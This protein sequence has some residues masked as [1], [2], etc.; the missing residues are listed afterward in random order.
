MKTP[1][2]RAAHALREAR[3]ALADAL[4]RRKHASLADASATLGAAGMNDPRED[5]VWHFS[6]LAQALDFGEPQLFAQHARWT[7]SVLAFRN[8][9]PEAMQAHWRCMAEAVQECLPGE[10]AALASRY[11]VAGQDAAARPIPPPPGELRGADPLADRYLALLLEGRKRDAAELLIAALRSKASDFDT[12]ALSV[13]APAMREAGRL[14]QTHRISVTDEHFCSAASNQL[15]AQLDAAAP[16]PAQG[17][18]GRAV[19]IC[20]AE[21]QHDFGLKMVASFMERAGW[22]VMCIGANAPT[23]EV[24]RTVIERQA[25]LLAVSA[26]L[27]PHVHEVRALVAALRAL[28]ECAGTRVLV[29]GRIFNEVPGLWQH[30]GADGWAADAQSALAAASP[31]ARLR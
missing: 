22:E 11:I 16:V 31:C 23:A 28:P 3:G 12:L 29:G 7:T 14:W 10:H 2:G 27:L 18:Q 20:I 5:A 6:H 21:E 19:A 30:T 15:L 17:L 1:H 13:L 8:A 25:D 26:T 24:M 9:A 4:I